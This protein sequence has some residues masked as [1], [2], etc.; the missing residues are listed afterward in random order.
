M[1]K[2]NVQSSIKAGLNSG[3]LLEQLAGAQGGLHH[4]LHLLLAAR[5]GGILS[6]LSAVK[7]RSIQARLPL[8]LSDSLHANKGQPASDLQITAFG[9]G[10]SVET[11][12]DPV[13]V[14]Q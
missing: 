2:C 13:R 8:L 1:S 5:F 9:G 11:L 6:F 4:V 10:P 12:G 3:L 14:Q 7:L